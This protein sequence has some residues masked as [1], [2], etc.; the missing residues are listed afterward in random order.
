MGDMNFIRQHLADAENALANCKRQRRELDRQIEALEQV[1]Q[2]ERQVAYQQE[3][4][5]NCEEQDNT[6]GSNAPRYGSKRGRIHTAIN[7]LLAEHRTLHR[8]QITEH[9]Q[10]LGLVGT[11]R[12]VLANVSSI[13]SS[14]NGAY[15]TDHK[16]NWSL[17]AS[18][19]EP[20]L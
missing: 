18:E 20:G 19:V 11:E 1:V 3:H 12:N 13:L 8:S 17:P 7:K 15:A 5:S 9:L 4:N 6:N 10:N 16:G 2:I 14:S